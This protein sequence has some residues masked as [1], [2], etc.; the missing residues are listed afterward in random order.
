MKKKIFMVCIIIILVVVA[1]FIGKN[2]NSYI[3]SESYIKTILKRQVNKD[4][5]EINKDLK[6]QGLDL[7]FDIDTLELAKEGNVQ[8]FD[9]L[10]YAVLSKDNNEYISWVFDKSTK[11]LKAVFINTNHLK[12]TPNNDI[13]IIKEL[14]KLYKTK[15]IDDYDNILEKIENRENDYYLKDNLTYYQYFV[16]Q[17]L[18]E[19]VDYQSTYEID[20]F[21]FNMEVNNE[22]E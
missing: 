12:D 4:I 17:N 19:N 11:E 1:F 18:D 14:L 20:F 7:V 6:K 15:L 16:T 5:K 2:Y 10:Q 9:F 3:N 21:K 8:G 22:E 13:N